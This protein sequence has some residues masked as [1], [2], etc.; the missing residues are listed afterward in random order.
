MTRSKGAKQNQQARRTPRKASLIDSFPQGRNRGDLL[1]TDE[2]AKALEEC[3]SRVAEISADCR[4]RNRKFRSASGLLPRLLVCNH[5]CLRDIE[6]DLE[7][8]K[9]RCLHGRDNP[10][11][12]LFIPSDVQ[13]A[14]QIFQ[15]PSF[16][17]D[18]PDSND[19]FQEGSLAD[20][21]F[22]SALATMSTRKGLVEE[23]CVARDEQVG[24]YGFIFFRDTAWVTVIIDDLLFTSVPK[25][26]ELNEAEKKLYHHDKEVYNNSARKNGK[27]LYFAKSGT[28]GET[29][30]PLIEKAYAKLHGNYAALNIGQAGEAIED[31]TGGVT[32]FINTKDILDPDTFWTT[33]L[34]RANADRLFGCAFGSLDST[35]S[36]VPIPAVNGLIGG[37]AYSVLRA[38]EYHDKRF[39]VI[40]NPWGQ[41][42]WTGPWSDGS[43][44]WT[45]EWLP[46]LRVLGHRFGDDGEFVM[47]YKDF[48]E[49]WEQI[50]RTLLFDSSWTM[51]SQ[52]LEVAARPVESPWAYGDVSF[53][54]SLPAPSPT[55]IVLSNLDDRYW[56]DIDISGCVLRAFDFIVYKKGEIK[57][58]TASS[59]SIC[60]SRSV[61]TE[62]DLEAGEYVVHVRLDPWKGRDL[63]RI[64][65]EKARSQCILS[66]F[67]A[68]EMAGYLPVP[69]DFFAGYDLSELETRVAQLS[70]EGATT[71]QKLKEIVVED[72]INLRMGTASAPIGQSVG[73]GCNDDEQVKEEGGADDASGEGEGGEKD[74]NEG[75][76]NYVGSI[77]LGLRV[78]T[79]KVAPAKVGGQLRCTSEPWASLASKVGKNEEWIKVKQV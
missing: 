51:S 14:T 69:L 35:R 44:E 36:G 41:N 46:A 49:N 57:P 64:M 7:Y 2:L 79:N 6:F 1:V 9:M 63:A 17:I 15:K 67:N 76:D 54:I 28:H 53:T 38:V 77:Y 74:E 50:D 75:V 34:L 78:Y 73:G 58:I 23:F 72:V 13:R 27:S 16:F 47:E 24:V 26:E 8:D 3:K 52:W 62:V 5:A 39:I 66:N 29:W 65:T 33:E 71:Q 32:S 20:C 19:I 18:G 55:I 25:F 61:N 21:W 11:D 42:E 48:L 56:K 43:K 4:R 12:P 31:L 45:S 70:G 30:V 60:S 59:A 22:L 68:A 37:H 40:R 10:K